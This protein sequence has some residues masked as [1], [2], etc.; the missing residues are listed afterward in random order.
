MPRELKTYKNSPAVVAPTRAH[1]RK[2]LAD[3]H[4]KEKS[5]WLII[6]RKESGK[7]CVDYD[8]A[9][10]EALCF[11]WIDSTANRRDHESSY[12]Y[13]ARR[14][15]GSYWSKINRDRVTRLI[16][17]KKMTPAGQAMIDLAKKTGTWK[18]ADE[19]EDLIIPMDLKKELARN[20]K[21]TENFEGFPPSSKKIILMWLLNAKTDATRAKRLKET[22]KLA[23]KNIRANHYRQPKGTQRKEK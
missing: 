8:E 15:P 13:F 22:V 18:A 20:R 21:A 12:R 5:A 16:K 14:K 3:N 23:A 2:W 17:E 9:V 6:F 1:W 19:V 11:G 4:D 7:K 10:E